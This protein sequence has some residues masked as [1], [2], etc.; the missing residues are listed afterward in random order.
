MADL[1]AKDITAGKTEI[2]SAKAAAGHKAIVVTLFRDSVE[3]PGT[4]PDPVTVE[5]LCGG[6]TRRIDIPGGTATRT[7]VDKQTRKEVVAVN[8]TTT[9]GIISNSVDGGDF[10]IN[11]ISAKG[12][13]IKYLVETRESFDR[14][15]L[16]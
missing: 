9:L 13:N 15:E 2:A 14:S 3:Y 5:I 6:R 1:Q 7:Y 8:K 12:Q 16:E 10:K 11:V 4:M